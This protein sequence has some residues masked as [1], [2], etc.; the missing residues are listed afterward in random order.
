MNPSDL[1]AF[2]YAVKT[3]L[4]NHARYTSLQSLNTELGNACDAFTAAE[5]AAKEGGTAERI[6]RDAKMVD[7][8]AML[9][10]IALQLDLMAHPA[11]DETVIV[12]AGFRVQGVPGAR[13]RTPLGRAEILTIKRGKK[14]GS[15]QGKCRPMPGVVKFSLEWSDDNGAHWHNGTYSQ[16]STFLLE[17]LTSE[18]RYW[19]RACPLGTHRRTGD[20]SEP[21]T[22]FVL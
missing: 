13:N 6:L 15:I 2:T 3:N 1:L 10:K 7:I 19:L 12:E 20:W 17:G 14:S 8:R 5:A 18:K 11:Q 4:A 21:V 9:E 16:G 22:L